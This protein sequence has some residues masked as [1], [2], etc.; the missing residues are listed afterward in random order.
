[1]RWLVTLSGSRRDVELL[2]GESLDERLS[3]DQDDPSRLLL[4]LQDPEGDVT[5][6]DAPHAAKAPIDAFVQ[7]VNS[8][9]RL[10]WG[11]TF[12]GFSVTKITSF[13][14]AGH[15]AQYAFAGTAHDHMLP[16][17]FADMVER[18]GHPRPK[19]PAGIEVVNALELAPVMELAEA[20]PDVGRVLHLIDLM[21]VGDEEIDWVAGYAALEI[22]DQDLRARGVDGH[23]RG[24]WTKAER[25]RFNATANSPEALGRSRSSRETLWSHRGT[26]DLQGC[27]LARAQ[28]HGTLAYLSPGRL[29][30]Q[31]VTIVPQR[32]RG[33]CFRVA[34]R[35]EA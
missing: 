1:M 13:D 11:R 29:N 23:A 12:E 27:E 31:P 17:D 24:W 21:L 7:E 3:V 34:R 25:T 8:F 33:I 35:T 9:G 15:A 16:E 2:T 19:L 20:H 30:P 10:R 26:Y 5:G 6:S 22:I 32:G 4:E 14:S 18:P 28:G